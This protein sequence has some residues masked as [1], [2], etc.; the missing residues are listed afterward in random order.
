MVLGV[1]EARDVW[2]WMPVKRKACGSGCQRGV[3]YV[4]LGVSE[5]RDVW[6]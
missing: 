6:L 1:S 3:W 5:E 4:V 2:F